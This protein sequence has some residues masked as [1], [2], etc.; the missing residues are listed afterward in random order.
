[1]SG[2]GGQEWDVALRQLPSLAARILAD[3]DRDRLRPALRPQDVEA[4]FSLGLPAQGR[5]LDEVLGALGDILAATPNPAGARFWNQLFG[6]RQPAATVADMLAGLANNSMYTYKVA[7]PM[8]LIENLVL[9]RMAEIAGFAG[10]EAALAPGGSISNLAALLV[11]RN[12][13]FEGVGATGL[14]GQTGRIYASDEAHYSIRKAAMI[15]GIGR[16]NVR[17]VAVDRAGRMAPHD[18]DH[19]L[20]RDKADGRVPVQVV[21]TAG[22]TVRG[23]FDPIDAIADVCARHGVWLHVDGAFGGTL[24]L[25]P[26]TRGLLAG[27]ERADSFAWDAHKL[28]GVPLLCSAVFVRQRG[29]LTTQLGESASYLFQD[30][31]DVLNPGTRSL[32]CGRRNDALKLWAAWQHLGD[33]GWQA[34]VERQRSLALR[35]AALVE[36]RPGLRLCE[37]PMSLN[38]CF[39]VPDVP[40][41]A[42]C[43]RLGAERL[44]LVGHGDVA[45]EVAIRAA[46]VDPEHDEHDLVTLL[47]DVEAVAASLRTERRA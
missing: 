33:A 21:A 42:I 8:V 2:S 10:G 46:V 9:E 24:L 36:Q 6:G 11:A 22:T 38:V 37:P 35:L 28:M 34:R 43:A 41:D 13:A 27:L 4:A 16:D 17:K 20:S 44:Q 40:S 7:G 3:G 15:A 32:Q 14:V 18:L 39:V 26:Q 29:Q 47:D 1:M 19:Q 23:A 31:S 12:L 30:D 25:S 45:G 5:P